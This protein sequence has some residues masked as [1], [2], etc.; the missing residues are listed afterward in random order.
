MKDVDTELLAAIERRTQREL[1][2]RHEPTVR[3][4]EPSLHVD[5]AAW[6]AGYLVEPR[7][8]DV[9]PEL[10]GDLRELSPQA[11]LRDLHRPVRPE[12]FVEREPLAENV[13]PGGRQAYADAKAAIAL[14]REPLPVIVPTVR[15]VAEE[16]ARR[17]AWLAETWQPH[18]RDDEPRPEVIVKRE[19]SLLY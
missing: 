19:P 1:A 16:Q 3:P 11:L 17:R 6:G 9:P 2:R 14:A 5:P 7:E 12:T 10:L 8:R 4:R 18:L 15:L 13:D